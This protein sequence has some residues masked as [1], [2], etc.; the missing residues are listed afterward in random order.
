MLL[1]AFDLSTGLAQKQ[2]EYNFSH[3][4]T[5]NGLL[6]NQVGTVVQDDEGYLGRPTDGL[7]RFR[8]TRYKTF[9]SRPNDLSGLPSSHV[10]K[11][12]W[13]SKKICPLLMAD[14]NV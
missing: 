9:R 2:R 3:Y 1:L 6:S 12:Y 7:Q 5:S 8:R 11:L 13:I 4:S 10:Q 14:G